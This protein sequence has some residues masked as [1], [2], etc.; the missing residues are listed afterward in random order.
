MINFK[1]T[2][3]FFNEWYHL[4]I[5]EARPKFAVWRYMPV[6]IT[7]IAHRQYRYR[8]VADAKTTHNALVANFSDVLSSSWGEAGNME[9]SSQ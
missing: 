4:Q 7:T 1:E 9:N 2:I 5:L 3:K 8:W 6:I